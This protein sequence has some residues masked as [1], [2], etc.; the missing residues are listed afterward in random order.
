[1]IKKS[2]MY[3]I[4]GLISLGIA[5]CISPNTAQMDSDHDGV[6]NSKDVCP[7]TPALAMVDKYGC[8]IDSDHDGVIDLY[9]KCPNTPITD[10]VDKNGCTIKKLK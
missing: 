1:M 5:G 10:L 3:L 6:V 4:M 2:L 8:A 9:D 7:N